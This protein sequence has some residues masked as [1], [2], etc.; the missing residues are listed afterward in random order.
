M[1]KI[2]LLFIGVCCGFGS[3]FMPVASMCMGG[4]LHESFVPEGLSI[5]SSLFVRMHHLCDQLEDSWSTMSQEDYEEWC[6]ALRDVVKHAPFALKEE[7]L[8]VITEFFLYHRPFN[9]VHVATSIDMLFRSVLSLADTLHKKLSDLGVFQEI[10]EVLPPHK[11]LL[12][13]VIAHHP[14]AAGLMQP[15]IID[16]I[17]RDDMVEK[18]IIAC[19]LVSMHVARSELFSYCPLMHHRGFDVVLDCMTT[20]LCGEE[21]SFLGDMFRALEQDS[22]EFEKAFFYDDVEY[23]TK[24]MAGYS[25][26]NS[27]FFRWGYQAVHC[28]AL[29]GASG[30]AE[31]FIRYGVI[32]DTQTH[33]YALCGNCRAF[34]QHDKGFPFACAARELFREAIIWH[35]HALADFLLAH[36]SIEYHDIELAVRSSNISYFL[37]IIRNT[38]NVSTSAV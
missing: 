9:V 6:E 27:I 10:W 3:I 16:T 7:V 24:L 23:V 21:H 31:V 29:A 5:D 36:Y 34:M 32:F 12:L 15:S 14:S 2:T 38:P 8:F 35:R 37:W 30:L 33:L 20:V 26:W 13:Y 25:E 4:G 1:K 22:F 18:F 19:N 28:A 17:T 11:Q